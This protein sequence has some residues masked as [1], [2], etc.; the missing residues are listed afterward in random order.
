LLIA[1]PNPYRVTQ[2]FL[3]ARHHLRRAQLRAELDKSVA[4]GGGEIRWKQDDLGWVGVIPSPP[5]LAHDPRVVVLREGLVM[6]V[7]PALR[8]ELVAPGHSRGFANDHSPSLINLLGQLG[9]GGGSD[10]RKRG[11]ALLLRAVNLNRLLRLPTD[12]PP[13]SEVRISVPATAPALARGRASFASPADAAQFLTGVR[14]RLQRAQRSLLLTLLGLSSVLRRV[15]LHQQGPLIEARLRLSRTEVIELL[16]A[17]RGAIPQ[18]VV[19]GMPPRRRTHTGDSL[20][21]TSL[22]ADFLERF[23]G[24][25]PAP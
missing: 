18:V 20:R 12:L 15:K 19:P 24:K 9:A 23:K 11:P 4:V 21:P 16:A 10:E 3:A 5:R 17:F 25:H 8:G 22:P 14:T 6:L 7:D 1:T 13:P 2:T